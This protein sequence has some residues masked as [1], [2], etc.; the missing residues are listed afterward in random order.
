[1]RSGTHLRYEL[2]RTLR[3]WRFLFVTIALPL[4]IFYAVGSGNRHTHTDGIAFPLYFMTGMAVYGAL[5]AVVSPG[6]RIAADRA[7]GWTRQIRIAPLRP[8]TYFVAKVLAAYLLALP[9]LIVLFLAGASLG[10][11][12][13]ATQWLEMTGLLL[14]GLAPFV[15]MGV[16]IGHLVSVDT[17]A[18]AMGGVVVLFA[19]FGGAFGTLFSGGAALSLVKALPSFWLVQAG[20]TALGSGSWPAEGWIVVA[21]WTA[22]LVPLAAHVYRR[23]TARA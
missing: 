1:M 18:P 14:I 16:I 21:A 8:S 17:T 7:T 6:S 4:V 23:D 11:R 5:F 9:T 15:V 3:N 13:E 2:L 19:L 10:V 12:L 20:K 22:V